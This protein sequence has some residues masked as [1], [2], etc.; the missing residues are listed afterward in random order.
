MTLA[1]IY[2]HVVGGRILDGVHTEVLFR[3]HGE[4]SFD[5]LEDY[6]VN[7]DCNQQSAV[8][9]VSGGLLSSFGGSKYREGK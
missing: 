1:G 7:Q 9:S 4:L 2:G 6:L 3:A 8:K 5:V